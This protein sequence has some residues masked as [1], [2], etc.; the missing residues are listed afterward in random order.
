M[1]ILKVQYQ[2]TV[3]IPR[4]KLCPAIPSR[5][6]YLR[7]VHDVISEDT[8]GAGNSVKLHDSVWGLDIGVGGSCVYPLLGCRLYPEWNFIGTGSVRLM[9]AKLTKLIMKNN[10]DIQ[11]D[12]LTEAQ[13]N[14]DRNLDLIE[15][16]RLLHNAD[17]NTLFPAAI[18]DHLDHISAEKSSEKQQQ[19]QLTFTVCNPP[20]YAS[21]AHME[22]SRLMKQTAASSVCTGNQQELITIGGER[23]F[24]QRMLEQS[25]QLPR[26]RVQW[27][28]T[29]IGLKSDYAWMLE[30]LQSRLAS[31]DL[32][33]LRHTTLAQG[34]TRRWALAWQWAQNTGR[35]S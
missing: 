33:Q 25:G 27:F 4:D 2:L 7:W 21:E 26:Q 19:H 15:R 32:A 1:A 18:F 6:N 35:E 30:Q 9:Y 10:L 13:A 8:K 17:S 12:S 29:W 5:V 23:A 34:R 14:V 28:T 20:F 22:E 16:I 11:P 3:V 24:L 31:G